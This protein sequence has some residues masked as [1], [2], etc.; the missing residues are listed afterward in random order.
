MPDV[1][2]R[3]REGGG[4]KGKKA[5]GKKGEAKGKSGKK[6]NKGNG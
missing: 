5:E 2:R 4:K 1:L 6:K 3:L